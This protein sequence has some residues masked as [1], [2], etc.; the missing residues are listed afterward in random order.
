MASKPVVPQC[1]SA[2]TVEVRVGISEL[3]RSLRS[4]RKWLSRTGY[5]FQVF[6]CVREGNEAVVLVEFDRNETS[7][8]DVFSRTF[9]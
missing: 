9:G 5:S 8:R 7:V 3:A 4:M 2:D 1:L 6:H